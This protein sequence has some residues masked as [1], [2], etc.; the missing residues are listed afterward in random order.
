MEPMIDLRVVAKKILP[1]V[2]VE[3]LLSSPYPVTLLRSLK[4]G[5]NAIVYSF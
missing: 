1:I 5:E 3:S 2:G 4:T